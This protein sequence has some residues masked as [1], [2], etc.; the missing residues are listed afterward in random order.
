M[1]SKYMTVDTPFNRE[2]SLRNRLNEFLAV[3]FNLPARDYYAMLD[4]DA[5]ISLKSVFSD[6]NNI[7]TLRVSLAF[8]DWVSVQF[9]LDAKAKFELKSMVFNAKPNANGFDV[10]CSNPIA[11]VGEVKC[12]IPINKS[13][14]YGA[15]QRHGIE[16]D[17]TNLLQGK[18]KA[19]INPQSCLKFLAF[20]DRAEIRSANEHLL[21]VSKKCKDR[22]IFVSEE[23]EFDRRD[24]VYGIY[25]SAEPPSIL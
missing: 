6:I 10:W 24:I 12:N 19:A 23:T 7:L 2:E 11:F 5:F 18:R 13:S 4:A 25:V 16:K 8:V 3:N 20:L 1:F 15:A 17:V 14:V 21:R 9:K 22:L